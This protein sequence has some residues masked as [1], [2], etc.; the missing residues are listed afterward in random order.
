MG[1]IAGIVGAGLIV[2]G[3]VMAHQANMSQKGNLGRAAGRVQ[4]EYNRLTLEQEERFADMFR[5]FGSSYD[6]S[7]SG[8][9]TAGDEMIADLTSMYDEIAMGLSGTQAEA[10]SAYDVGRVNTLEATR[11]ATE[12]S[13]G[14]QI[15]SNVFGGL[16]NTTFGN[17]A[18]AGIRGQGALQEGVIEEQY[19]TG[20]AAMMNQQAM[21]YAGLRSQQAGAIGSMTQSYNT[22]LAGMQQRGAGMKVDLENNALSQW[23]ALQSRPIDLRY[24]TD[25][26]IAQVPSGMATGG[27][28]MGSIGGGLMAAAGGM[29]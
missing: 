3:G 19:A 6:S 25:M 7:V 20:K 1:L 26:Q 10:L 16:G 22:T 17:A 2:G 8:F 5:R 24:N 23:L 11:R 14:R 29:G 9:E 27:G 28:V 12:A 18:V 21:S 15:A 4:S 13:A